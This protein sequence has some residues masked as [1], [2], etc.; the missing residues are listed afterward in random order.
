MR[1]PDDASASFEERLAGLNP[2]ARFYALEREFKLNNYYAGVSG[3]VP[4]G[5]AEVLFELR[6]HGL[7]CID[8]DFPDLDL[9]S[10]E[11][12]RSEV[13]LASAEGQEVVLEL[14]VGMASGQVALDAVG[15]LL[16]R[17]VVVPVDLRSEACLECVRERRLP[18][19]RVLALKKT[20]LMS[21]AE[22]CRK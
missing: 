2:L 14:L 16:A 13:R 21:R 8:A 19:E 7:L 10:G 15:E 20:F 9:R 22:K 17:R 11:V 3:P 1:F 18:G 5:A 12:S 6:P 4:E